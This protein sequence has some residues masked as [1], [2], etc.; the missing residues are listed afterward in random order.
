MVSSQVYAGCL[1]DYQ[2]AVKPE[3]LSAGR[4]A[5]FVGGTAVIFTVVSVGVSLLVPIVCTAIV[6]GEG[7]LAL[8]S[9]NAGT[10]KM[11]GA[12][13][14]SLSKYTKNLS[15]NYSKRAYGSLVNKINRRLKKCG[16]DIDKKE[17]ETLVQ[18]SI[19]KLDESEKLCP[20]INKAKYVFTPKS[21]IGLVTAQVASSKQNSSACINKLQENAINEVVGEE[22]DTAEDN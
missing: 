7:A 22:E 3:K 13:S 2:D 9:G 4:V 5:V 1:S 14:Y 18:T 6:T 21:F 15:E 17:L 20:M 11:V 12:Y 19:N 16:L 10:K 8:F